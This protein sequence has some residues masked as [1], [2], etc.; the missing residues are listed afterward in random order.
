MSRFV[1]ITKNPS[2]GEY[3]VD[4]NAMT[5]TAYQWRGDGRYL[6]SFLDIAS[7]PDNAPTV[8]HNLRFNNDGTFEEE[9]LDIT[10][11]AKV[12]NTEFTLMKPEDL[13]NNWKSKLISSG[14]TS[15]AASSTIAVAV[16]EGTKIWTTTDGETWID[17]SSTDIGKMNGV[18]YA[19]DKGLFVA[20]G[21]YKCITS[22]D[23]V[24]WST[25]PE[26]PQSANSITYVPSL[27][28]FLV[29]CSYGYVLSSSDGVSWTSVSTGISAQLKG[30]AYSDTLGKYVLVGHGDWDSYLLTSSDFTTWTQQ[31][32]AV[33]T[34]GKL[35][36]VCYS[37]E[38]NMFVAVGPIDTIITSADGDTWSIVDLDVPSGQYYASAIYSNLLHA[39]Y[40]VGGSQVKSS[41][42]V[43]WES[44]YSSGNNT[45]LDVVCD[46]KNL[47]IGCSSSGLYSSDGIVAYQRVEGSEFTL[48]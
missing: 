16:G 3:D 4:T 6:C 30:I 44:N 20:V 35:K 45:Y 32:V 33:P 1:K 10:G 34:N 25:S 18:A 47:L 31:T 13:G 5:G 43:N 42:G 37:D 41:D 8:L 15:V 19:E 21:N 46:F 23:G 2:T 27:E 39:F 22:S 24:N 36:S 12:S 26:L 40:I 14:F 9:V 28:K 48:W 11:Y 17:R 38:L 29:A 7:S